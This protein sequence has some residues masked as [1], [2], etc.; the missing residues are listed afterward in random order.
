MVALVTVALISGYLPPR[1]ASSIH[2]MTALRI[3]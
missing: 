3:R 2:P 1:R